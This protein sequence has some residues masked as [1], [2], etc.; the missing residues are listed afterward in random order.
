MRLAYE[1]RGDHA[2]ALLRG[3]DGRLGEE[4]SA[5]LLSRCE[6]DPEA[7]HARRGQVARLHELL[8]PL[9]SSHDGARAL[10]ELAEGLVPRS[11]WIVGGDGWAYDIGFGGL[12]HV[13]ASGRRVN[14]L[15]LDTGVYSNTGG[16]ASKAT[17]R[18]AVAKFA[19][20]GRPTRKKDLG[21]IAMAYGN[22]YVAQI[23]MGSNPKQTIRALSEA[24][25][26]PG[27]SLVIAYSHCIAHGIRMSTAMEHQKL[28]TTSGFWPLFR[29][30]PRR[31]SQ[32]LNPFQ[33]DSRRPSR[34]LADFASKEARFANLRRINPAG[35][36]DLFALAQRDVEEQWGYYEHLAQ[37]TPEVPR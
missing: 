10:A 20:S 32:G 2:R 5:A 7:I 25:S 33:L 15:V 27:P 31:E 23:A 8:E 12:D 9:S 35:A 28:A 22:V 34:P 4:L 13:L 11:V 14:M 21:R 19:S 16:Q 37:K 6:R 3:L 36:E 26:Y 30:D 18:A 1:A 24:E 17:P 29:H